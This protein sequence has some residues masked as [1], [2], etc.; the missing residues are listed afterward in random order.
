MILLYVNQNGNERLPKEGGERMRSCPTDAHNRGSVSLIFR[1][2][3]CRQVD[4]M[5]KS[6]GKQCRPTAECEGAVATS[7]Y[8][9]MFV[10]RNSRRSFKKK[11]NNV[12]PPKIIGST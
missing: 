4:E 12:Y 7:A 3:R 2:K 9:V 5:K 10:Q 8:V 1:D 6:F 11:Q